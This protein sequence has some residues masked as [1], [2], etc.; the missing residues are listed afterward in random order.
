MALGPIVRSQTRLVVR[1]ASPRACLPQSWARSFAASALLSA[2][3]PSGASVAATGLAA[4]LAELRARGLVQDVSSRAVDPHLAEAPRTIYVG[5]D[6]TAPSL[7]VGHLIPI[8]C[9]AQLARTGH[10]AIIVIGGATGSIGDPSGRGSER[11]QL[12][13]QTLQR[14]TQALRKQ[15]EQL[16]VRIQERSDALFGPSKLAIEV[17]DNT[18]WTGDVTLLEFLREVG[19]Y[20]RMS[21]MLARESVASRLD[22]SDGGQAAGMSFTEFAYQLL[23]AYDFYYLHSKRGCTIQ[24]GGS[25]QM[26]NIMAGIELILRKQSAVLKDGEPAYGITLPLLLTSSGQK[27]GKSAGNALW[28]TPSLLP[29]VDFYQYFNR[30][31]DVDAGK[32]LRALT[33]LPEAEI[34]QAE[35]DHLSH[36]KEKASERGLQ[37]LLAAEAT[38]LVRGDKA[39]DDALLAERLLGGHAWRTASRQEIIQVLAP[40]EQSLGPY[41]V[42]AAE[43]AAKLVR[44]GQDVLETW[45]LTDLVLSVGNAKSKCAS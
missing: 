42:E 35:E 7:H 43:K 25:D 1:S 31:G 9:L 19:K 4:G 18:E 39:V 37:R 17:T 41:D 5:V 24:L 33:L 27:I 45:T 26:G 21:D 3:A 23:Q 10:R 29:H 44:I 30:L 34:R 11:N 2:A 14:N 16:L 40:A 22:R 32:A 38:R 28:L 20:S 6:P 8:L 15:V 13:P 12:D 36:G